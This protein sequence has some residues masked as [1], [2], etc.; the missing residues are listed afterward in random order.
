VRSLIGL[1]LVGLGAFALTVAGFTRFYIAPQMVAA[2]TDYHQV[3]RLQATNATYFDAGRLS[4]RT[5]ATLTATSTIRGDVDASEKAPGN[6]AV[7]DTT[8]VIQDVANNVNISISRQRLAFDRRTAELRRCCGV[9]VDNDRNAAMSGIGL[10]WPLDIEPRDYQ[11]FDTSTKRSWPMKY[12]GTEA[13]Q[14]RSAYKFVQTIPATKVPSPTSEL[15]GNLLG[16]PGTAAVPVDRYHQA[17]VSYWID[18]RTGIPL[19]QR[20][21]ARVTMRPRAGG[22][23]ELVLV[24]MTMLLTPQA[25][26]DFLDR[27]GDTAADIRMIE[28]IIPLACLAAGLVLVVAGLVVGGSGNAR[29]RRGTGSG[30]RSA[31][32]A[33]S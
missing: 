7:W 29:H 10:F 11:Y 30:T 33:A 2:P 14:G 24:D 13:I 6:T 1:V 19:D 8:A 18:A 31:V 12:S 21:E 15:P 25:K 20:Q 17:T 9:H 3:T 5:G 22:P 23:G 26:A 4:T 28:L 16:L 32:P 27:A